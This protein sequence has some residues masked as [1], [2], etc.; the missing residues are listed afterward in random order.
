M[1]LPPGY[2]IRFGGDA[3]EQADAYQAIGVALVQAVILTYMLLAALLGSYLHPFTIMLTLPLG[4][5]GAVFSMTLFGLTINIFSLLALIM[6]VGI[7]VNDAILMLD[8]TRIFR[9]EGMPL[10]EALLKACPLK[11]TDHYHDKLTYHH[12]YVSANARRS[13]NC[14]YASDFGRRRNRGDRCADALYL[15]YH[16]CPLHYLGPVLSA[17]VFRRYDASR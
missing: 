16:P 12:Q 15:D 13:G 14:D 17:E 10:K 11:I 4:F 9:Q 7:V 1:E 2:R 8:Q 6:L 3:E 5:V